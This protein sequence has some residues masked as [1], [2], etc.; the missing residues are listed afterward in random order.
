MVPAVEGKGASEIREA[1]VKVT[2]AQVPSSSKTKSLSAQ[3][4]GFQAGM[5]GQGGM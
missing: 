5:L 4:D 1:G 2:Q 3:C